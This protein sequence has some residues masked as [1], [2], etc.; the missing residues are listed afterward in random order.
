VQE[1]GDIRCLI[2][3]ASRLLGKGILAAL[4][5]SPQLGALLTQSAAASPLG[6]HMFRDQVRDCFEQ[7]R[8]S[9]QRDGQQLML[10]FIGNEFGGEVR[11]G[12]LPVL[13]D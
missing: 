1:I 11:H 4:R 2:S 8:P 3:S 9:G 6:S 5:V 10:Q 7:D 12:V 13:D